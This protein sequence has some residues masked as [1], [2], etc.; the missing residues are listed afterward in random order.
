MGR[1]ALAVVS[2]GLLLATMAAAQQAVPRINYENPLMAF[3]TTIPED[4][5]VV[6]Q[7][8]G[9]V[10]IGLGAAS[11]ATLPGFPKIWFFFT[12]HTPD[13]EAKRLASD[14]EKISDGARAQVRQTGQAE[15]EVTMASNGGT[16]GPLLEQWFCRQQDKVNYVV[17]A[18]CSPATA[19][20]T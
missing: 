13:D 9:N 12:K 19:P 14:L 6:T 7:L 20:T 10:E 18:V 8:G 1:Y 4:W 3:A 17:G 11:D 5:D 15:W 16:R 2:L